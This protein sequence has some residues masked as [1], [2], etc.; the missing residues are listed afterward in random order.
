MLFF[1]KCLHITAQIQHGFPRSHQKHHSS[2][3]F[4]LN[5][6]F[7]RF[8]ID[9]A[10]LILKIAA[11]QQVII[12][13]PPLLNAKRGNDVAHIARIRAMILA[14]IGNVVDMALIETGNEIRRRIAPCVFLAD[15]IDIHIDRI[16][17]R[18]HIIVSVLLT[19]E[20]ARHQFC[21]RVAGPTSHTGEAGIDDYLPLALFQQ[22]DKVHRECERELLIIVRV[23]AEANLR[24]QPGIEETDDMIQI[25]LKHRTER[26]DN[27]HR[28]W[29][30]GIDTLGK[31][32]ELIIVI[33]KGI[34]RLQEHKISFI[35]DF[36]CDLKTAAHFA[37][38]ENDAH[39]IDGRPIIG[40]KRRDIIAVPVNHRH[41]DGPITPIEQIRLEIGRYMVIGAP[42]LM[43]CV[44]QPPTFNQID[45]RFLHLFDDAFDCRCSEMRP[46][47]IGTIS[48]RTIE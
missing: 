35:A 21:R 44:F 34:G 24:R 8:I 22:L 42:F 9:Q 37:T 17:D 19:I 46:V 20:I 36:L 16:E 23:K 6:S 32:L 1:H 10:A 33:P 15:R 41:I 4:L 43:R 7:R 47:D 45:V 13:V 48:Q 2:P 28:H 31:L 11:L 25:I 29:L 27:G 30:E 5:R 40:W 39:G 14:Q 26:I 38:R 3:D 18:I 12:I